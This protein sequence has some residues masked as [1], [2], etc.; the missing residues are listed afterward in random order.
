MM[1]V[2]QIGRY[3]V[4]ICLPEGEFDTVFY[5]VEMN[6]KS[7]EAVWQQFENPNFALVGVTGVDWFGDLSPWPAPAV[8]RGAADFAGGAP[9]L[10]HYLVN[11]CIPQVEAQIGVPKYRGI[12]GY[13]LA[14]LFSVYAFY[15][16]ALF[17]RVGCVS[18]SMW[19]DG[20]MDYIAAR[21]PQVTEARIHFSVGDKE[22]RT[23]NKRMCIVDSCMKQADAMLRE[24]GYESCF[25]YNEGDHMDNMPQRCRKA[26]QWLMTN[27]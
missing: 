2:K 24:Q 9:A 3:E 14:G 18:G 5:T 13:S 4:A 15:E 17:T 1:N 27:E 11:E 12:S 10:L 6:A 20:F 21:K 25:C 7:V 22:P 26:V 16:T 19:Y 8:F 23:K